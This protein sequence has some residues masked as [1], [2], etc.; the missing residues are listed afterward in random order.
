MWAYTVYSKLLQEQVKQAA[1]IDNRHLFEAYFTKEELANLTAVQKNEKLRNKAREFEMLAGSRIQT[2][3][4]SG[5]VA[6]INK[7]KKMKTQLQK[8]ADEKFKKQTLP[9]A[10]KA[11]PK[12]FNS[13]S[14]KDKNLQILQT[15]AKGIVPQPDEVIWMN[16][17]IVRRL[18]YRNG[19]R[20]QTFGNMSRKNFLDAQTLSEDV[21]YPYDP[22]DVDT[23]E[24]GGLKFN[25]TRE[26]ENEHHREAL[27]GKVI[28]IHATKTGQPSILWISKY[29]LVLMQSL[30]SIN[31]TFCRA[32]NLPYGIKDSR[33]FINSKGNPLLGWDNKTQV[34][35]S[36]FEELTGI[37]AFHSHQ[38]RNFMANF[39][40]IAKSQIVQ[41]WLALHANHSKET[42]QNT[43]VTRI[44][45]DL[46]AVKGSLAYQNYALNDEDEE[47]ENNYIIN[48]EYE[49]RRNKNLKIARELDK[50][51]YMEIQMKKMV[52]QSLSYERFINDHM[53]YLAIGLIFDMGQQRKVQESLGHIDLLEEFFTGK[54][55]REFDT[56]VLFL[57]M[58]DIA[59]KIKLETAEDLMFYMVNLANMVKLDEQYENL[60]NSVILKVVEH[61][62]TAKLMKVFENYR[63]NPIRNFVLEELLIKNNRKNDWKY[64]F[65]NEKIKKYLHKRYIDSKEDY[66]SDEIQTAQS[67]AIAEEESSA[68]EEGN[69][70]FSPNDAYETAKEVINRA[71]I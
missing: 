23:N 5:F 40:S 13:Q 25:P 41:E 8:S 34:D 46:K 27:T 16:K 50:S 63:T 1:S 58:L 7:K 67:V 31:E 35:H 66:N 10:S 14:V 11:L 29:D 28:R 38:T 43:Y 44:M 69:S 3:R 51:R 22:D 30:E 49:K 24:E 6:R 4:N 59:I 12:Y 2:M 54:P 48:D 26:I 65:G 52:Q 68:Y 45:Q 55:L 32:N 61:I 21:V 19:K 71:K 47:D 64:V 36:E 70:D 9:D 20:I 37:Q 33:F 17:H 57:Q 18:I 53:K 62:F 15:A 39:A 42:Q 56:K 60:P